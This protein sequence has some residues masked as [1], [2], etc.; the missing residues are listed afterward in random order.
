ML[1][2][3]VVE[4]LRATIGRGEAVL[5]EDQ[6]IVLI[7]NAEEQEFVFLPLR[8]R[9]AYRPLLKV[10]VRHLAKE[11]GVKATLIEC[12]DALGGKGLMAMKGRS[13]DLSADKC[14][15]EFARAQEEVKESSAAMGAAVKS[16][17]VQG[18]AEKKAERSRQRRSAARRNKR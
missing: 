9:G 2:E 12:C 4:A 3:D 18:K 10:L 13:C 5:G 7:A 14:L 16:E 6:Y 1:G 8:E 11:Q 17:F 15:A